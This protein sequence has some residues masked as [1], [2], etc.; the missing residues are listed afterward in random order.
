MRGAAGNRCPY[1]DQGCCRPEQ[2]RNSPALGDWAG[3]LLGNSTMFEPNEEHQ[4]T[5]TWRSDPDDLE[6]IRMYGDI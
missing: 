4:I 1:R 5:G 6:A 3:V 2:I